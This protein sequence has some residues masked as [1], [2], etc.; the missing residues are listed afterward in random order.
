[1]KQFSPFR[2]VSAYILVLIAFALS[3]FNQSCR[4]DTDNKAA[5]QQ[6]AA[7]KNAATENK[8]LSYNEFLQQ[9]KNLKDKALYNHF[10]L[11]AEAGS[12]TS[13]LPLFP[14]RTLPSTTDS[15]R[16]ITVNQHTTYTIPVYRRE[17]TGE[18]FRNIIIDSSDAGVK[19]YLAWY[20]P[21]KNWIK[22]YRSNRKRSF[23]GR[24]FL[25]DYDDIPSDARSG[26]RVNLLPVCTS[27]MVL[28]ETIEHL[29]CHNMQHASCACA[30]GSQYHI[31]YLYNTVTTCIDTYI[32]PF[33]GGTGGSGGG[34]TV[35]NPG[36]GYDP[37]D[38]GNLRT[39]TT[40]C[41]PAPPAP[42]P[43]VAA[44]ANVAPLIS[45]AAG[46]GVTFTPTEVAV[47]NS[48]GAIMITKMKNLLSAYGDMVKKDF[49]SLITT[50]TGSA[51][52]PSEKQALNALADNYDPYKFLMRLMYASNAYA[53]ETA[54]L[55]NYNLCGATCGNCKGNA[56]K[57]ALFLIYNAE[58]FTQNSAVALAFAH[59]E[60]QGG[61][62]TEMDY[63]NNAAGSA[64][65]TVFGNTGTPSEWI[66]RVKTAV[67]QGTHGFVFVKNSTLVSTSNVDPNCP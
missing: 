51:L 67:N 12:R 60:G 7:N 13:E 6:S 5:P 33:G 22:E 64:I 28:S 54:T 17:H 23:Y 19:A 9:V 3:I 31:E 15:V 35:P 37:C 10:R 14:I 44:N 61:K 38:N 32:P 25:S 39:M 24:V 66:S 47:L 26:G 18:V 21:D 27:V 45:L 52:T 36:G 57:H 53:A 8:M 11:N 63:K 43:P 65:F 41:K 49:E 2:P 55:A 62:D 16:K 42:T 59:E 40:P 48:Q 34:G 1:M 30:A 58:T 46:K 50:L 56:F 29:C 20:F 4:D